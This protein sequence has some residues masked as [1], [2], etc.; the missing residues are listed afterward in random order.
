MKIL[1][2]NYTCNELSGVKSTLY[3]EIFINLQSAETYYPGFT[4]WYYQKVLPDVICGERE[5]I[6]E[7]RDSQIVGISII[8]NNY[9]KKLS[10][11]KVMDSYQNKGLG[12]KLFEKS[13][14]K[15]ETEKPFLTVSEEKLH[16]FKKVFNY[17][18]FKLT[19]IHDDLYRKSKKEYFF[20]EGIH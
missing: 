18:G 11:L 3:N 15:L 4:E 19:S 16:E 12:L 10:T 13:F 6:T 14:E 17:Y 8:K 2:S 7:I 20:N 9:E 1:K 5:I